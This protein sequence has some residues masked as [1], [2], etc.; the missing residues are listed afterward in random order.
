LA[1][2][3]PIATAGD[4][5]TRSRPRPLVSGTIIPTSPAGQL[6]T[7]TRPAT[8]AQSTHRRSRYMTQF[9]NPTGPRAADNAAERAALTETARRASATGSQ[10]GSILAVSLQLG[11]AERCDQNFGISPASVS[12]GIGQTSTQITAATCACAS[13]FLTRLPTAVAAAGDE[14]FWR[15][16]QGGPSQSGARSKAGSTCHSGSGPSRIALM[17]RGGVNDCWVPSLPF[18]MGTMPYPSRGVSSY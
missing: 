11:P 17:P 4:R 7:S 13:S 2:S 10:Q 9:W 14:V 1:T 15:F 6:E 12:A 5:G 18:L 8:S 16:G 3:T